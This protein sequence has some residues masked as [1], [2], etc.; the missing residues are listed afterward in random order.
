MCSG[1][2]VAL[3][4]LLFAW[5]PA[6]WAQETSLQLNIRDFMTDAEYAGCGLGQLTPEQLRLLNQ[7]LSRYTLLLMDVASRGPDEPRLTQVPPPARETGVITDVSILE[8]TSVVAQD[9]Q[10]LGLITRSTTHPD[11]IANKFGHYGSRYSNVSILNRYGEYG[12]RHSD[13]SPFSRFASR[14]PIVVRGGQG[15]AFLTVNP[16]MGPRLDPNLLL[17]Y[18][19]RVNE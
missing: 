8:G 5:F 12:G 6:A 10:Y 19:G 2:T 1:R 11:S 15:L 17:G 14:P 18:L 3:A 4:V 7:W 9:G 16:I 13:L